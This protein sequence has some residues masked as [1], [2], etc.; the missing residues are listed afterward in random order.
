MQTPVEGQHP[1][2]CARA[3]RCDIEVVTDH[4][5]KTAAKVEGVHVQPKTGKH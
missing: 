3:R 4:Y 1:T 5:A 2:R